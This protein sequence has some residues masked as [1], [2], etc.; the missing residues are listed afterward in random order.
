M[1][2]RLVDVRTGKFTHD[3]QS[4]LPAAGKYSCFFFIH[5][6]TGLQM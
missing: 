2:Y 4:A 3:L 5:M 1:V 6:Y